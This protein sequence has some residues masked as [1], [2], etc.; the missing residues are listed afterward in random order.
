MM[1]EVQAR[2]EHAENFAEFIRSI[3]GVEVSIFFTEISD[4]QYKVSFRSKGS[5]DV[6]EIAGRFGGGGHR[7]AAACRLPGA[8]E[9]VRHAVMAAVQAKMK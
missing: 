1:E 2:P 8:Y 9:E 3:S 5:F 6:E 7:N 4:R